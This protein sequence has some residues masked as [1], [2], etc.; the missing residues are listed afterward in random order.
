MARNFGYLRHHL[1]MM[2]SKMR[3]RVMMTLEKELKAK[4]RKAE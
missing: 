2:P 4:V 1:W 3:E